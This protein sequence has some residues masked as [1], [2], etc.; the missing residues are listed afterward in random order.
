MGEEH[1]PV[2]QLTQKQKID[3]LWEAYDAGLDRAAFRKDVWAERR[4]V[5]V[6]FAWIVSVSGGILGVYH[7]IRLLLANH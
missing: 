1:K 5:A 2:Q 6:A 7:G 4:K 3:I